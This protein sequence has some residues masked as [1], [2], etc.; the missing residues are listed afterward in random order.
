VTTWE[1]P[2]RSRPPAPARPWG[3]LVALAA[4]SLAVA[5]AWGSYR[6]LLAGAQVGA[7]GPPVRRQ[8]AAVVEASPELR[9]AVLPSRPAAAV[10]MAPTTPTAPLAARTPAAAAPAAYVVRVARFARHDLAEAHARRVR[11]KGYLATVARDGAAYLVVTRPYPTEDAAR[12][13]ARALAEIGF[14]VRVIALRQPLS[15]PRDGNSRAA[16]SS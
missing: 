5:T 1:Q 8:A 6:V 2:S 4:G 3:G 11:A 15:A 7:F 14:S 13:T 9:R 16:L 10:G 12:R